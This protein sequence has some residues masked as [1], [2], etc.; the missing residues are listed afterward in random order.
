MATV[1]FVITDF[2]NTMQPYH[3]TAAHKNFFTRTANLDRSMDNEVHNT[4][5]TA[6]DSRIGIYLQSSRW[7]GRTHRALLSL[8]L[9][10]EAVQAGGQDW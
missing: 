4:T 5:S 2:M 8:A 6:S 9:F 7:C 10:A 3:T 1:N